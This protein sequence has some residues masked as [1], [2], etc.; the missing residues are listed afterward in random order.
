MSTQTLIRSSIALCLAALISGC[1]LLGFGGSDQRPD[2]GVTRSG[3]GAC[4][5]APSSCMYEGRYEPGEESY[6]EREARRLNQASLERLRR[7][8]VK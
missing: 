2:S 1:S 6:A 3:S 4:A 5:W 7:S 8:S